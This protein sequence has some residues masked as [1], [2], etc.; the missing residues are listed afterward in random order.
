M[1]SPKICAN[2]TNLYRINMK[3][4]LYLAITHLTLIAGNEID[5]WC[6]TTNCQ[7]DISCDPCRRKFL[8]L[9]AQGRSGSTTLKNM[10]NVLP[11]IRIGGE[12]GQTIRNLDNLFNQIRRDG[13]FENGNGDLKNSWGHN[14]YDTNYLACPAMSMLE[15]LNP[16][17]KNET[18]SETILGIKEIQNTESSLKFMIKYLPCARFIF[19]VRADNEGLSSALRTFHLKDRERLN[20]V[21]DTQNALFREYHKILG[22]HKSYF[23]DMN[24]WRDDKRYFDDLAKWLG[25]ENC[26]Y[27]GMFHDHNG[28]Y[29]LDYKEISV[30]NECRYVGSALPAIVSKDN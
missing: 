29:R 25:Y 14:P 28:A 23:M 9:L 10:I 15:A 27:S 7:T 30:G 1:H 2:F 3:N 20:A 21:R 24:E 6:P 11:G 26:N 12:T 18:D 5:P 19:N 4:I 16:P 8:F 22:A 13:N 17:L